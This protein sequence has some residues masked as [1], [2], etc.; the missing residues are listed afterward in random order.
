MDVELKHRREGNRWMWTLKHKR[1]GNR[2][3]NRWMWT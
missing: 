3:G 1:E 2:E